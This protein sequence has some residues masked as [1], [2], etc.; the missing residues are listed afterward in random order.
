MGW[1]QGRALQTGS[2]FGMNL[3]LK[4]S[5]CSTPLE[6]ECLS[7]LVRLLVCCLVGATLLAPSGARAACPPWSGPMSA[8]EVGLSAAQ[9]ASALMVRCIVG[10]SS[11]KLSVVS[12]WCVVGNTSLNSQYA[13]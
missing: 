6:E 3:A 4:Y 12:V 1:E 9:A 8:A 10:D 11:A 2:G 5:N 7:R 13:V